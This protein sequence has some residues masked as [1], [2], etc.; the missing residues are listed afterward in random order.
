M[1]EPM[2]RCLVDTVGWDGQRIQ[3]VVYDLVVIF[4][5]SLDAQVFSQL[6]QNPNSSQ[7]IGRCLSDDVFKVDLVGGILDP[8]GV[9]VEPV[10][11]A[12]ND[13]GEERGDLLELLGSG[14]VRPLVRL[15][16]NVRTSFQPFLQLFL[17]QSSDPIRVASHLGL[18][19]KQ[20]DRI[21]GPG[22]GC[23][24]H[25]PTGRDDDA[26][27][28]GVHEPSAVLEPLTFRFIQMPGFALAV[29]AAAC[30]YRP[31]TVAVERTMCGLIAANACRPQSRAR[32]H[33]PG[34]FGWGA[35]VGRGSVGGHGVGC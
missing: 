5:Q 16:Q 17:R 28:F 1:K 24:A 33:V 30:H 10:S 22:G 12:H 27:L 21:V 7:A 2:L 29:A 8:V 13:V 23:S 35:H 20:P 19:I 14:H 11:H 32:F 18:A 15:D 26:R 3:V 25:V 34:L 4:G 31:V 6:L 9:R